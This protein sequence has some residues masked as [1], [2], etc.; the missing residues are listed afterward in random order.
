MDILEVEEDENKTVSYIVPA[1]HQLQTVSRLRKRSG[2]APAEATR[3]E[4]DHVVMLLKE[5][6][7]EHS[8]DGL[9]DTVAALQKR[10]ETAQ[11]FLKVSTADT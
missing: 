3:G 5:M 8:K 4:N 6:L 9:L 11:R 7:G 2:A 10:Q 1:A